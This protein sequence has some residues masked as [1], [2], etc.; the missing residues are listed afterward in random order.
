ME[1]LRNHR[2][3]A[4]LQEV[5]VCIT[6]AAMVGNQPEAV[7]A[8]EKPSG[9][10]VMT[11]IIEQRFEIDCE[12]SA[13]AITHV[14]LADFD[15]SIATLVAAFIADPLVRW[16]FPNAKQYFCYFP[17]LLKHFA[18]GALDHG[19]AYRSE[20]FEATAFWLPPSVTPDEEAMGAVMEEAI[21]AE[22][23]SDVFAVLEQVGASH[24]S[25]EHWYLPAIGVEPMLQGQG[26]GAALLARGL[27]VCDDTHIASYLESSN[28]AGIPFYKSF[29]FEV[30]GEIQ[31][32]SSSSITPM[33]RA[34]R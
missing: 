15:R 27:E 29:G 32:G 12:K 9:D 3:P 16:M 17:Q 26:Y 2:F 23:Q 14:T 30:V 34:A 20:N 31:A 24:P 8:S 13:P 10:V 25:V 22:F 11:E 19:S 7:R 5:K 33:F 28:P 18:G 4:F 1:I 21:A 6:A